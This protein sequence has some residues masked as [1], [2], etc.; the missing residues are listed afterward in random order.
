MSRP[1]SHSAEPDDEDVDA[2]A[3]DQ[4]GASRG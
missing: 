1:L 4:L 3:A 2:E